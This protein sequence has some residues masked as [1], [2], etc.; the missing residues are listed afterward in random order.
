MKVLEVVCQEASDIAEAAILSTPRSFW[1]FAHENMRNG[2]GWGCA[3]NGNHLWARRRRSGW[4]V[5]LGNQRGTAVGLGIPQHIARPL[6][7]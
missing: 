2:V 5:F 6:L 4:D 7:Q 1:Q 3:Q